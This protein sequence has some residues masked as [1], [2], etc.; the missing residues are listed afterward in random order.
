MSEFPMD[1]IR[2]RHDRGFKRLREHLA[3]RPGIVLTRTAAADE[4]VMVERVGTAKF[5]ITADLVRPA[6]I[7]VRRVYFPTWH[8]IDMHSGQKISYKQFY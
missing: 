5:E 8:L 6:E 3:D 1:P 7:V 2:K 4:T